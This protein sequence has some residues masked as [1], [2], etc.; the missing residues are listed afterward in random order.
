[1]KHLRTMLILAMLTPLSIAAQNRIDLYFG[2]I[3]LPGQSAHGNFSFNLG[4]DVSLRLTDNF[5]FRIGMQYTEF[6]ISH[7]PRGSF[8]NQIPDLEKQDI[9]FRGIPVGF[10]IALELKEGKSIKLLLA[11]SFTWQKMVRYQSAFITQGTLTESPN[12]A[13]LNEKF[14]HGSLGIFLY[15]PA[16]ENVAFQAGTVLGNYPFD[17]EISD[18]PAFQSVQLKVSFTFKSIK[19]GT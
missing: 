15:V 19:S 2:Y 3:P 11:P 9:E 7:A 18:Y 10:D 12:E 16:S 8:V 4:S 17:K 14:Y 13:S 6:H 5:S 1:M